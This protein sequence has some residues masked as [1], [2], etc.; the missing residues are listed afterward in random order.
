MKRV[1]ITI[2]ILMHAAACSGGSGS[3]PVIGNDYAQCV[4]HSSGTSDGSPEV[5]SVISA[6]VPST[7]T[8]NCTG[9]ESFLVD[10]R[11]VYFVIVPYGQK[12]DCPA[13]CFS[14]EVCAVVDG[15]DAQLYSALWY[16]GS[17]RPLSIPPDCPE[18]SGATSGETIRDCTNQPAGY[19]HAVTQTAPFQ[20][21][22]QAQN[23][24]GT[25]RFCFQ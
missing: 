14:S 23:G 25:F 1:V 7:A 22:K 17:E 8:V 21:F 24:S 5:A 9:K 2:L 13:G 3:D 19:S 15:A 12:N 20:D 10:G 4:S 11:T 18:L 6:L 16:T